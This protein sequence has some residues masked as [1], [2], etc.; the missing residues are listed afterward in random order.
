ML[1]KLYATERDARAHGIA[2]RGETGAAR[3]RYAIVSANAARW[4]EIATR[5]RT[6]QRRGL[7]ALGENGVRQFADDYREL[8]ADLARLRTATRGVPS[9]DVFYLNR[10]VANAH[11]LLYRG[12]SLSLRRVVQYLF[13]DV[14]REIRRA[15]RP[16]GLAALLLFGPM[17][18]AGVAVVRTPALETQLASPMMVDRADDGVARAR[19][20]TGYI[21]A[22]ELMRPMLASSIVANNVQVAFLAFALGMTAGTLTVLVLVFNGISIGA[23]YGL[24]HTRGIGPLLLAFVAP[25]G[26]LELGAI[27][28]AGA[29]GFLLAAGMLFP[30]DRTRRDALTTNGK[31]AI[32]LVAGSAFL[33]LLAGTLE[34]FV[35]P[36]P[37]WP[38]RD[39]LLVSAATAVVLA[40]Y[41]A[42]R[43]TRR[44]RSRPAT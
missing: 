43:R 1:A 41:L 3:E 39:K 17:I 31:R 14:P 25:H 22:P 36:I 15:W 11:S 2:A 5:V 6:A 23:V 30:G 21:E 19:A 13:D 4:S 24:Y 29:A 44:V 38:L 33:L 20:G 28:I 8:T 10:L 40:V 27:V 32:H 9:N 34:G 26:V 42:P 18:I 12:K 16:V 37:T 7:V 35:S